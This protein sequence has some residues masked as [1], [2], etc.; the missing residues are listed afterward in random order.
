M[1][2]SADPL[3]VCHPLDY[4]VLSAQLTRLTQIWNYASV[5]IIAFVTGI[6]F[7]FCFTRPWDKQEEELNMLQE[8][9]YRGHNLGGPTEKKLE[10][11][12]LEDE[13]R[14]TPTQEIKG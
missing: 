14:T 3:L 9:E 8:S 4:T 7:Y 5:A 12:P 2:L 1:A 11:G 13:R 6:A 10:D